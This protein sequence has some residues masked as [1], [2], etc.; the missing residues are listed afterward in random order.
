MKALLINPK[1]E[2]G[3]MSWRKTCEMTGCSAVHPPLG[4]LTVAALLPKTWQLRLID[5]QIGPVGEADWNWADIV[6]LSGVVGTEKGLLDLIAE[7][8]DRRKVVVAGGPYATLVAEDCLAAGCNFVVRGEA[9]NT[10]DRLLAALNGGAK[11]GVIEN[12]ER[13]DLTQ[14]PI[15]RF[16]LLD[17]GRYLMMGVQTSR[18]CP[19][20]CE[21]CSVVELC[22]HRPRYKTPGQ[23][24]KELELL[25]NLGWRG[26]VLFADDNF[27]GNKAEA[28]AILEKLIP[29]LRDRGDP[30]EFHTQVSVDLGRDSD[31]M[32]RMADANF[33]T[34]YVGIES[35]D[36]AVLQRAHKH[37]NLRNHP[38]ELVRNMR[39]NGLL[40]VGHFVMGFD[41]EESGAGDRIADFI[42]ACD[43]PLALLHILQALPGT[44][45][46]KRLENEDR[47][48]PNRSGIDTIP[49]SKPN[50]VPTRPEQDIIC[51][52]NR[53]WASVYQHSRYLARTYRYL[54]AMPPKRSS[55][56]LLRGGPFGQRYKYCLALLRLVWRRGIRGSSR[57]QFWRQL[58]HMLKENPSR[59]PPYLAT[60][61]VGESMFELMELV[62]RHEP[63]AEDKGDCRTRDREAVY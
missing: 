17:L 11:S 24:V 1:G 35:P 59:T 45:F 53:L 55:S 13:A 27:V 38:V 31:M 4:L 21:F 50:F 41:G 39:E 29:W 16:E 8:K 34:V 26:E 12:G 36:S 32:S 18:G 58:A 19:Y 44:R 61:I 28:G 42:E 10:M 48:L 5:Q 30:F 33:T 14:S 46:W 6:L 15:P 63:D 37:Q 2:L 43:M 56:P 7:C 62:D 60:C 9:E 20:N 49:V 52:Y 40:V 25:D 47:L 23:V 57:G 51:E 22:G 3:L 54:V